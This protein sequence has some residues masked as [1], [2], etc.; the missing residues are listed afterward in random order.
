MLVKV[1]YSRRRSQ[2]SFISIGKIVDANC[3]RHKVLMK[4]VLELHIYANNEILVYRYE[5]NFS[6]IR[7]LELH[8]ESIKSMIRRKDYSFIYDENLE[9]HIGYKSTY[10][11]DRYRYLKAIC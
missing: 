5:N 4:T 1:Y 6:N 10:W 8:A 3:T 7:S 9:Y 2:L 11:E